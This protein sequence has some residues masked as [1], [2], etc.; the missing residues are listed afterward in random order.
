MTDNVPRNAVDLILSSI[1][2]NEG[3]DRLRHSF[4]FG[5]P[6]SNLWNHSGGIDI[7]YDEAKLTQ[8][9][10]Y[11]RQN[12]PAFLRDMSVKDVWSLVTQ[13]VQENFWYLIHDVFLK[14]FDNSYLFQ[15]SERSKGEFSAALT[16]SLIF[17]PKVALTLFPLVPI[18]ANDNFDSDIF[19]LIA[20][21]SLDG[22][23]IPRGIPEREIKSEQFPPLTYWD[24]KAERPASWLGVRAPTIQI[25]IKI[26][27]TIV[28]ALALT[29]S[30]GDRY[31][32]SG[33][34]IFGGYCI[35]DKTATVT[36]GES[37]VPPLMH[38][39]LI[40]RSDHEWL[41]ILA[42]KLD[43][44]LEGDRKQMRALEYLCRAWPLADAQRFPI[45]FMAL[46]AVFGDVGRAT[47]AVID[48]ISRQLPMQFDA[49][50][51]K[52]LL[53]LRASVVHGGA[54][55]V[56]ESGKYQKYYSEYGKSPISDLETIAADSLRSVIFGDTMKEHCRS[57]DSSAE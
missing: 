34:H 51:L 4:T 53:G 41:Q 23:R 31:L 8:A 20:P 11:I 54:P 45:L 42:S 56:H 13:F 33:R 9:V 46:D 37:H 15:V 32:F 52:L 14:Q 18:R 35:L 26:K 17:V 7:F 49:K 38:D 55:D 28:G 36:F 29:A 48:A 10:I 3:K 16:S 47:Q 21:S 57:S 24:G 39:I 2:S 27:S 43:S 12:G 22:S 50:Q 19:F 5:Q 6:G 40:D 1:Y 44:Q 25:S 30:Q